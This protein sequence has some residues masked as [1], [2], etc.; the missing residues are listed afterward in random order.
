MSVLYVHVNTQVGGMPIA[1]MHTP[2]YSQPAS[3]ASTH[4][5]T[6]H[7]LCC[8]CSQLVEMLRIEANCNK[9]WPEKGTQQYFEDLAGGL[10]HA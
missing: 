1:F 9:W 3:T 6:C 4:A 7:C 8:P 5:D 2:A 10:A